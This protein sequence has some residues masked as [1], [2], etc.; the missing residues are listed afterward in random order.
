M[1]GIQ[2]VGPVGFLYNRWTIAAI[3]TDRELNWAASEFNWK[4]GMMS[5]RG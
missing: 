3:D 1:G 2:R 4:V 5:N